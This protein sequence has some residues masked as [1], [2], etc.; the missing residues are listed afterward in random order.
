MTTT[1]PPERLLR[2]PETLKFAGDIDT[3]TLSNW[4]KR[5]DFPEPV[6]LN[7]GQRREIVAWRES[8]LI[9]W[10][11]TRPQRA[12]RPASDAAYAARREQARQRREATMTPHRARFLGAQAKPVTE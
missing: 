7:P 10:Q 5:G 8:D 11:A 3:M 9:K 4:I 1:S 12:A 6:V 2:R